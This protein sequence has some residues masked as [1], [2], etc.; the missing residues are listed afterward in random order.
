MKNKTT[1]RNVMLA[2]CSVS[3]ALCVAGAVLI[4]V[5]DRSQTDL[6]RRIIFTAAM[7]LLELTY[8]VRLITFRDT[9]KDIVFSAVLC[10]VIA[11]IIVLLW[12]I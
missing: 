12:V 7:A 2:L 3:A 9:K 6:L 10:A 4:F 8:I 5:M 11:V 1:A